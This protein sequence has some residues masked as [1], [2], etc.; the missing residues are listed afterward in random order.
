MWI[1][2]RLVAMGMVVAAKHWLSGHYG[3]CVGIHWCVLSFSD[4]H[5]DELTVGAFY[6]SLFWSFLMLS[7]FSSMILP[8][9]FS[10]DLDSKRVGFFTDPFIS[11]IEPL[12]WGCYWIYVQFTWHRYGKLRFFIFT[13]E[14]ADQ[15]L[16][17]CHTEDTVSG[18]WPVIY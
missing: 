11:V 1:D 7:R 8:P 6:L 3:R 12:L 13:D 18:L 15:Y 5:H 9:Q 2:G 17:S 16:F 14:L 4:C 10:K